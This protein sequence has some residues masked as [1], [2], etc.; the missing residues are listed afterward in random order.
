M[1]RVEL[2][3][4]KQRIFVYARSSVAGRCKRPREG[5]HEYG[6]NRSHTH[7]RWR[8]GSEDTVPRLGDE[9]DGT[10][11]GSDQRSHRHERSTERWSRYALQTQRRDCKAS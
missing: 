6:E 3:D 10:S 5:R 2:C 7:R 9:R 11:V 4:E 1:E 8:D